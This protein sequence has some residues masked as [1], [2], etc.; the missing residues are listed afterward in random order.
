MSFRIYLMP[1]GGAGTR[2]DPRKPKYA[3]SFDGTGYTM[4]DYGLEPVCLVEVENI[5]AGAHNIV[6]ANPDVTALPIDLSQTIGAQL[7]VVQNTLAGLN[8]PENWVQAGFSYLQVLRVV[9][10]VFQFMQRLHGLL[11]NARLFDTGVTLATRINQLPANVRTALNAAATSFG[12]DTAGLTGTTT[13]RQA[14]KA[15]A[16]QFP[17]IEVNLGD[18]TF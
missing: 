10:L 8:I 12:F 7:T 16:D 11:P 9:V 15:M 14:L 6:A 3:S 17:S 13:L 4:M 1:I 2:Q 18:Q 5:S